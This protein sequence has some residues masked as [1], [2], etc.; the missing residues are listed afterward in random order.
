MMKPRL[1]RLGFFI[2]LKQWDGRFEDENDCAGSQQN[3]SR[4]E[5]GNS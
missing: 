4:K 1:S 5:M 3:T 2:R